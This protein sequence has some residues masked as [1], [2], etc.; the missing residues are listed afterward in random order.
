MKKEKQ[1]TFL[2]WVF[3]VVGLLKFFL[4]YLAFGIIVSIMILSFVWWYTKH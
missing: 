2:E 1:Y 4:Y 3:D